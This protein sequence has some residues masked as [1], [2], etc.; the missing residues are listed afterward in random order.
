[1]RCDIELDGCPGQTLCMFTLTSLRR[2]G[3]PSAV[4]CTHCYLALLGREYHPTQG[5]RSPSEDRQA[6]PPLAWGLD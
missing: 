1:M 2:S 5:R 6:D 3:G 4:A